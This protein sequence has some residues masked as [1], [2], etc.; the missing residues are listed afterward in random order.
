MEDFKYFYDQNR[1]MD[2]WV[3][4]NTMSVEFLV[5]KKRVYGLI[6]VFLLVFVGIVLLLVANKQSFGYGDISSTQ[7]NRD[8]MIND[9]Q[10]IK[11]QFGMLLVG[12]IENKVHSLEQKILSGTVNRKDIILIQGLKNELKI[13]KS[14]AYRVGLNNTSLLG[15]HVDDLSIS[16]N[17][18]HAVEKES[19]VQEISTLYN[20]VYVGFASFGLLF[21]AVGGLWIQNYHLIKRLDSR[22]GKTTY[23]IENKN[24]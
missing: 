8:R 13:L 20:F 10:T 3:M 11:N 22:L 4:S 5:R 16:T 19:L 17:L 21:T 14:Q 18:T 2:R 6:I 12:S 23:L 24:S 7:E 15:G 9:I 1:Q